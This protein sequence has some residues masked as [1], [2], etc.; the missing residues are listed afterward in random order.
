MLERT[1]LDGSDQ[2]KC[3]LPWIKDACK[4]SKLVQ[5]KKWDPEVVEKSVVEWIE[6]VNES[7]SIGRKK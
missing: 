2:K 6:K 7:Q 3:C 5:S 1:G 4:T